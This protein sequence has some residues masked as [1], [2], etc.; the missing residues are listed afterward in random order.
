MSIKNQS[1][2]ILYSTKIKEQTR[3]LDTDSSKSCFEF[4][5]KADQVSSKH[6]FEAA[7]KTDPVSYLST[8]RR[9]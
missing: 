7:D 6:R 3:E 2:L 8:A 9:R 4:A 5:D 1:L